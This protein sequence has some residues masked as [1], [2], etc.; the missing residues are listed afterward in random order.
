MRL[1]VYRIF[2][3]VFRLW[4][5]DDWWRY[6]M[7]PEKTQHLSKSGPNRRTLYLISSGNNM[8]HL[9]HQLWIFDRPMACCAWLVR[10]WVLD[11]RTSRITATQGDG[12]TEA[13]NLVLPAR[14]LL[15]WPILLRDALTVHSKQE[16]LPPTSSFLQSRFYDYLASPTIRVSFHQCKH[17]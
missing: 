15:T 17:R 7:L 10:T 8:R 13:C 1:C 16:Y 6:R 5:G 2:G 3:S 11:R 14:Y 12:E 4:S 9:H